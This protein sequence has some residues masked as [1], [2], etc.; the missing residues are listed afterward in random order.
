ME[1]AAT[2]RDAGHDAV[3]SVHVRVVGALRRQRDVPGLDDN[4]PETQQMTADGRTVRQLER[5]LAIPG[6]A[7]LVYF[8]SSP[9]T[10]ARDVLE[11]ELYI[12][13]EEATHFVWRDLYAPL[14]HGESDIARWL[15]AGFTAT[16][17]GSLRPCPTW[18]NSTARASGILLTPW[19]VLPAR[20]QRG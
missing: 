17:W 14:E 5:Y 16:G 19:S 20:G 6:I 8:R 1:S 12:R 15:L 4:A 7:G 11:H 10:L 18:A 2:R 3:Q 9:V 13:P